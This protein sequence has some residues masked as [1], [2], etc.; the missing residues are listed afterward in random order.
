ML[1]L[2]AFLV[3]CLLVAGQPTA[4]QT[5]LPSPGPRTCATE[6]ANATQQ[7]E[8]LRK[9]PNYNA[10]RSVENTATT[11]LR[12]AAVTYTLPVI[13][14]VINNGEAV[15]TGSNISQ[16]QVLSQLAVLNEDYRNL[17]AD[18]TLVPS[19]FQPLRSDMQLQFVPALRDPTGATLAE[20]GIDRVNRIT[21]G[22]TAPPYGSSTSTA[23]ID[24]TIKP[25]SYWDP[26]R[27]INI[28]VL[29]LG[30]GVLGYAQF[31]D[32]TAG[33]GG[34]SAQ[35]GSA[36]TDGVVILYSAFG[37]VGTLAT[38]YNQGRTL[39][40]ELGHWFGLR[41]I[42]GDD[43]NT[44]DTCSGSDYADDTPNQAI[45]NYGCPSFPHVSCANGPSGDMFMNY[46]DYV[47]DAC[48]QLFSASQKERMQAVMAAGTP[49][50]SILTTSNVA[51]LNL[52]AATA[53][54]S[55]A[56]CIGGTVT[57]AATGP[58]GATY[59]W[60]GPNNFTS[61]QQNP[62]LPNLT[63]AMAGTYTVQV[64]VTTGECTNLLSTN[65][66][67]TP[68][69]PT[70]VLAASATTVCTGSPATLSA[71]N[72][73]AGALLN[74]N[75]NGA[76]TGW[77]LANAGLASTAWQYRTAYNYSSDYFTLSNY[78]LDGSRFVLANSDAGG[79]G[80]STNTTLTSPTFSTIG[81]SSLQVAFL[82]RL[83]YVAGDVA[84]VEASTDGTTWA[85]VSAYTGTQGTTTAP[86][87]ATIDLSAYINQPSVQLRWRYTTSWANY[88][89]IDNVQV[90][91]SARPI[92]YA[93]TLVSGDGLPAVTNTPTLVVN[94]TQ[95]SV[96]RLTAGYNGLSCPST[97]TVS[98]AV[99]EPVWTGAAGTGNWFDAGN[100]TGCVPTRTTNATIPAGLATP[101]PT[102]AS[103]TAEVRNLVQLGSLTLT[104]GELDLY[105]N[106]LGTGPLA[107]SGGTVATRGT[108]A[109]S[110]R[111]TTYPTL[112][113]GGTGLKTIGAATVN[114]ALT[115]AG[116]VLTTGSTTLTL[117]PSATITETDASYVLGQVQTTH[118]VGTTT[119]NFGGLGLTLT[120][121][122]AP[123]TTTV[124]RTTGQ[125]LGS[126]SNVSIGRYYDLTAATSR[127][128]GGTTLALS[129][130]PHELNGVPE[131]QLALF[132]SVN[133]GASW[134]NEGATLRN[135]SS[136]LVSRDFVTELN[137]RWTLASATAPLTPAAI[138]YAI[139]ALPVPFTADG[140]SLQV[141]TP[142]AGPLT[143]Q[144]YDVLGRTIYNHEVATVAI[145]TS[146]LV[147]PN[148]GILAPGKYILLV[149]QAGQEARINVVRSQ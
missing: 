62:T 101:Y 141:T 112:L 139:T 114:A 135:P 120:P 31:P 75:F 72:L 8:L 52:V 30:G 53:N 11:G 34:L 19:V 104:G 57:L 56:A 149:Q 142:T 100:W 132:R 88:W 63:L 48:M 123:G 20:P 122:V 36:A 60:T 98:I 103:G 133:A 125:P 148:T 110:L 6:V 87:T 94:P 33:L 77:T 28:W 55:G 118:T 59:L 105:G 84:T 146:T 81:Y 140:L 147:L 145:G 144:L 131:A 43:N 121:N 13:V 49:R 90:T 97:A 91:G 24:G 134:S 16:A 26:N 117:A 124:L 127:S 108:S 40:H 29:D 116:G 3:G 106:H 129:Y 38:N 46:M 86:A 39:T 17:N 138:T 107:L 67:V 10:A 126:G 50:R 89:A 45:Q 2:Y 136:Q 115:L 113:V 64:A 82:Q 25:G 95:N 99:T 92:T 12:T 14:H 37:R 73:A 44:G 79:A 111:T 1:K 102:I 4:A 80:S 70:P 74:E 68:P 22:W 76:A 109:Q 51:C 71:P 32:N 54:S 128:L 61:T 119:D 27:Y 35:G 18:G 137:G 42:W 15:G 93:W 21:K 83:F 23:Y 66:V 47:N 7:A 78:S 58:A 143:V 96:Y 69:L 130:L 9:N 85:A 41:H 5:L 65:V